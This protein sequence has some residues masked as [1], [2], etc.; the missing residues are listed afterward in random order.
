MFLKNSVVRYPIWVYIVC[1]GLS[2]QTNKQK[3]KKKNFDDSKTD[4]SFTIADSNS[5]F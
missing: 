4:E 5:F 2:V 3:K 1:S